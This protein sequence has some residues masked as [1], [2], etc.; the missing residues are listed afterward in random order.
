MIFE[1]VFENETILILQDPSSGEVSIRNKVNRK[2]YVKVQWITETGSF[3]VTGS[4][5]LVRTPDLVVHKLIESE[6]PVD[7]ICELLD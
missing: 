6:D 4:D 2:S 3:R 7:K 1:K 5:F